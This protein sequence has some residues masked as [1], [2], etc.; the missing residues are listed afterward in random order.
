MR[1]I[2]QYE[3]LLGPIRWSDFPFLLGVFLFDPFD[4]SRGFFHVK[5]KRSKRFPYQL[6]PYQLC[7]PQL[8]ERLYSENAFFTRRRRQKLRSSRLKKWQVWSEIADVNET[9]TMPHKYLVPLSA[10][11]APFSSAPHSYTRVNLFVPRSPTHATLSELAW[12]RERGARVTMV[13]RRTRARTSTGASMDAP[14]VGL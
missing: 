13:N 3:V 5:F 14:S 1:I 11:G 12:T 10:I 6:L 2:G 9:M 7:P 8:R 4:K